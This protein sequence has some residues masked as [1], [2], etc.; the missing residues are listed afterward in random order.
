MDQVAVRD[1]ATGERV[2]FADMLDQ[3]AK[4]NAVFVGETHLDETT[5]KVELAIYE[6]VLQRRENRVVLSLEMFERDVQKT[7]DDYLAGRIEES[8]F[9]MRARPWGNYQTAYRRLIERARQNGVPVVA[10]NFPRPLRRGIG[11]G[12]DPFAKLPEQM[13]SLV[14]TKLLA[15]SPAYWRR[16]D[17]AVRGHLGMMGGPRAADDPRLTDMQSLWDNSMGEACANALDQHPDSSV[18]HVCGGFH[19]AYWDGTARQFAQ[20]K[21]DAKILTVDIV[22][23]DNPAAGKPSGKAR[24]DFVVYAEA[25]ANDV[26]EG[27]YSVITSRELRYLL[28]VPHAASVKQPVPLLI[29]LSDDGLTAQDGM[30]LWQ[31]RLGNDVAIAVLEAPYRERGPDLSESGRWFWADT[32]REDISVMV[33]AIERTWGYLLRN[34]PIDPQ[35]V[36]LVGE[37]AGATTV[38]AV[39]MLSSRLH[40]S[41]IALDPR[42]YAKIKDFP[43]PLPEL[44]GDAAKQ[45][46]QLTVFGSDSDQ[47]WWS[48]ELDE[49]TAIGLSNQFRVRDDDAWARSDETE[50]AVRAALGLPT[51]EPQTGKRR[52]VIASAKTPRARHWARLLA[53]RE[54]A[55]GER[56]AVLEK[57]AQPDDSELIDTAVR[58]QDFAK[59]GSRSL[60]LCPGS[61]GGT[62]VVVLSK[63]TPADEVQAWLELEKNDPLTARSR[64]HRLRIATA[65]GELGLAQVLDKL[66]A[67]NRNNVLIL[68][69]VFC[70]DGATMRTLQEQAGDSDA[71]TLHWLPGFGAGRQG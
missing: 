3:L 47:K 46:R 67:K 13:R 15:N 42:Q 61:F 36:A 57:G 14:P 12:D 58:A 70:A 20:R 24:A 66:H 27:S 16:V 48:G 22:P 32:F 52:H 34:Q 40:S 45:E 1:G 62:T 49:Y 39:T 59:G 55:E 2:A 69:A 68:P 25:R 4:A 17:N 50:Q 54:R 33:Q 26:N 71:M 63:D 35:R 51:N 60:P 43:L 37:G 31:A 28:H 41:S 5:H 23:V 11:S 53:L 8:A 19:T 21:P 30:D 6:G 10:A 44:R 9:L 56:I 65:S 38:A 18:L 64:F 29:W 7:L